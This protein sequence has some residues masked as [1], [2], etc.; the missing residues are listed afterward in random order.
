MWYRKRSPYFM[1]ITDIKLK[2]RVAMANS[3][4]VPHEP[5]VVIYLSYS[6]VNRF[7]KI[8]SVSRSTIFKVSN[9]GTWCSNLISWI[10]W[11]SRSEIASWTTNFLKESWLMPEIGIDWNKQSPIAS[12]SMILNFELEIWFSYCCRKIVSGT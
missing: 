6:S 9:W 2:I 5:E 8:T 7:C 3:N 11:K 10:W 1:K 12:F 4:K